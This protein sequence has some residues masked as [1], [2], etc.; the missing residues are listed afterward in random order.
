MHVIPATCSS[1]SYV[2][3]LSDLVKTVDIRDPEFDATRMC[4]SG[5][6]VTRG[7]ASTCVENEEWELETSQVN[8]SRTEG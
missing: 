1:P 7:N 4:C 5:L 6:L 2:L 8:N 3:Q